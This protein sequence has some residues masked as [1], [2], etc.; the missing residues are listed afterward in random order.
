VGTVRGQLLARTLL[1][2]EFVD[3]KRSHGKTLS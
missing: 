3:R 1:R 2:G